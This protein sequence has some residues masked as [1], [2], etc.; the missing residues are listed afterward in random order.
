LKIY[1]LDNTDTA[2]VADVL[3]AV[4]LETTLL[5]NISKS[6]GTQETK[7]NMIAFMDAYKAAKLD[8]AKHA[9]AITMK[10]S[11]LDK[12]SRGSGWLKVF[13][14]AESIGGRTSETSVVV[15]LPAVLA[16]IDFK[17]LL[18]GA[19]HMDALTREP[20]LDSNPAYMLAALWF[21]S[22]GG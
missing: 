9:C 7:N 21:I 6:G 5:V 11:E 22:G 14:M 12:L 8:Y 2:G 3:A 20:S 13:E 10:G 4:G 1:F 19:C 17:S 18:N 15:H 16:G